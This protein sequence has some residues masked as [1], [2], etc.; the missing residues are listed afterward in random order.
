LRK[1]DRATS[2]R[3][4]EQHLIQPAVTLQ[5][6]RPGSLS[7]G[8]DG[9]LI[10]LRQFT[11]GTALRRFK[12]GVAIADLGEPALAAHRAVERQRRGLFKTFQL[13]RPGIQRSALTLFLQPLDKV[14]ITRRGRQAVLAA[15]KGEEVL[16]QQR[17]AP[18]IDQDVVVAEDKPVM[19]CAA[20]DQAQAERWAVKQ[21]ETLR[22]VLGQQRLQR[23]F[24]LSLRAFGP[25]VK[26]H[27]RR[28]IAVDDLQHLAVFVE[29]ER[30]AQCIVTLDY[31][32]PGS[33]KARQVDFAVDDV[34]VLHEIDTRARFQ[35]GVHQQAL[36]H[37]RQ[38]VNILNGAGRH[39]E[40]VQLCLGQRCQREVRRGHAARLTA[41]AVFD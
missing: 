1:I 2:H 11:Q 23:R 39:L 40:V 9:Q 10:T 36:L 12:V 41:H 17:A 29:A 18:G 3:H 13:N 5:N 14:A 27:F 31:G 24:V 26:L 22:P 25:V 38:W 34:T 6:Q 32:V 16:Q 4:A 19:P 8:V 20:A 33:R 21:I 35:Q 15:V 37:R 30:S 7:Q 28:S